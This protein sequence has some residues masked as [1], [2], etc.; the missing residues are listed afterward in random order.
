MTAAP[1]MQAK[2][3]I[4]IA[5]AKFFHVHIFFEKAAGGGRRQ[6]KIS[7]NKIL[8]IHHYMKIS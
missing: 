6:E 5:L 3:D 2:I 4:I 7:H 8:A 1:T